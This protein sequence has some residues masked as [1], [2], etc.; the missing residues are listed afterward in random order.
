MTLCIAESWRCGQ[1]LRL[2]NRWN[3]YACVDSVTGNYHS[4]TGAPAL[5]DLGYFEARLP[6]SKVAWEFQPQRP[7]TDHF[8]RDYKPGL[9]RG[10]A[11]IHRIDPRD[12]S[13]KRLTRSE[14]PMWDFRSSESP[15]GR[16]ILFFA[17]RQENLRP[18]GSWTPTGTTLAC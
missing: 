14:P 4:S 2:S 15:D 12:G 9:A 6:E 13:V 5:P 16:Q 11:E 1:E 10:G 17:Q 3:P 7:D 8:N 18:S